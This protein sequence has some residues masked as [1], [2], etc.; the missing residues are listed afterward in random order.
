MYLKSST[1]SE[2]IGYVSKRL[3]END[4]RPQIF[5]NRSY[6]N[7]VK[8]VFDSCWGIVKLSSQ[9]YSV[10]VP[11]QRNIKAA[12]DKISEIAAFGEKSEKIVK[13]SKIW[14]ALSNPPYGYNEYTFTILFA[15]WVAYH[16]SEVLLNGGFG[17]P[18]KKSEQ[19]QVRRE[20]VNIWAT[21]N[22][23]DKPKDFVN[24]WINNGS[25]SLIRRKAVPYPEVPNSL[26]Y[27]RA[28]QFIQQ[29]DQFLSNAPDKTKVEEITNKRQQL[30][31][32][33]AQIDKLLEPVARAKTLLQLE[34]ISAQSDIQSLLETSS[35][36]QELLSAIN[37][38]GLSISPTQH[39]QMQRREV[40]QAVTERI[41]QSIDAESVRY[42]KIYTEAEC[43]KYKADIQ[44]SITQIKS[45]PNFPSR[46]IEALQNA[47][48]NSDVRLAEIKGESKVEKCL[49]K[50][51]KLYHSLSILATQSEYVDV[52]NEIEDLVATLP[53]VTER[54]NYHNI[55]QQ[56]IEKEK[57]LN[58]QVTKWEHQLSTTLSLK[59]AAQLSKSIYQQ[60]NRFTNKDD[61]QRLNMLCSELDLIISLLQVSI[62]QKTDTIQGCK[63]EKEHLQSWLVSK[64]EI[65]STA[66]TL[67]DS[68]LANLDKN[69]QTIEIEQR[70]TTKKWLEGLENQEQHLANNLE[71]ATQ[72][73]K[74]VKSDKHQYEQI[75]EA[76]QKQVLEKIINHCQEIQN[77]D[78][79][80]QIIVLFQELP[81][82]KRESLHK[83]ITK[84]LSGTTEEF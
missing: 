26:D 49:E 15:G 84:Y 28:Q 68:I 43:V 51:Q 16:R 1:G 36:L 14:E 80:S 69:Q 24:I 34:N 81:R 20:A 50:I 73:L 72:L 82:D 42:Q 19:V 75:L 32:A 58:Q 79:E 8:S 10:L 47:I 71:S 64:G 25:A 77:Q 46:F 78:K 70:E 53:S 35:E 63:L 7:V 61:R 12:W 76:E 65:T 60:I 22:V 37:E 66:K 5:P 30:T 41:G 18:Q 2:V 83:R 54:D 6:E 52:R 33:I 31:G 4:L 74:Q 39:Q 21:T 59:E 45:I 9:K 44:T 27:D 23:F 56:L 55:I 38:G 48:R 29:I 17:I 11:S 62:V 57:T 3:L 13:I 40:L 67:F